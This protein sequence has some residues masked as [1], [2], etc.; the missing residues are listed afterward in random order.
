MHNIV[1]Y[2]IFAHCTLGYGSLNHCADN[3]PLRNF[4]IAL[5][6][7]TSNHGDPHILCPPTT[8]ASIAIFFIGN[9]LAAATVNLPPAASLMSNLR[10]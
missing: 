4:T 7:E 2:L 6:A 8:W 3:P 10:I 9:Y 5:P 1:L